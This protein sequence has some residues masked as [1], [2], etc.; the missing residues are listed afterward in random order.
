MSL[1]RHLQR[2]ALAGSTLALTALISAQPVSAH[3]PASVSVSAAAPTAFDAMACPVT[4][5]ADFSDSWGDPR[6]GGR[7]H[8]GVDIAAERGTPIVA[9]LTG[10]AEFKNTSA[11]GKS[12]WLTTPSGDK[13]FYAHLDAWE[14]ESREVAQGD[15]LGYVGSTGN[16][17]GPHLHFEIRPGGAAVNPYLPTSAA[18]ERQSQRNAGIGARRGGGPGLL[19]VR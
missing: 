4:R 11:G 1:P 12:V 5:H 13:F 7:R 9:A 14:G 8:E 19:M 2:C 3:D 17:G 6:S 16:A 10:S 15:V 18:C